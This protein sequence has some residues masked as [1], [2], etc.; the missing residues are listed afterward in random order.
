MLGECHERR[1]GTSDIMVK[2]ESGLA[3]VTLNRP[4]KRNAITLAMWRALKTIFDELGR[5]AGV[6]AII[7]TGAGKDFSVGADVSE[8]EHIRDN[9]TQAVAYETAVDACSNAIADVRKP[10]IAA[11]SGYCLGGGCH[12]ALAGDFRVVDDTAMFGVPAA[13]LS[14]VYGVRSVQRLLALVG[15]SHAKRILFSAERFDAISSVKIGLIDEIVADAVAGAVAFARIMASNAPLSI[16]GAKV[17]LN[18][19]SMGAG[20][21][22]L[23]VAQHLIDQASGSEDFKEGRRAF[24]EKRPPQFTGS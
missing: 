16:A 23:A 11:V 1:A 8:F 6:R 2:C 4:T 15:I 5:D 19:L 21:L 20:A 12:L 24:A 3:V 18:G 13:K 7:L 9:K 14:I 17:M 22:D 10:V